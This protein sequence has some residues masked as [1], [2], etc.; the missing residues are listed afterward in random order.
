MLNNYI[1]GGQVFLHKIRMFMQ[2]FWRSITISIIIGVITGITI[3][4]PFLVKEDLSAAFSYRKAALADGFDGGINPIK[5]AIFSHPTEAITFVDAKTKKGIYG[6]NLDP[7]DVMRI[8]IFKQADKVV[9]DLLVRMMQLTIIAT[10]GSFIILFFLWWKFGKSVQSD[11]KVKGGQILTDTEVSRIL[12]GLNIASNFKIG[13]MPLVKDSETKHFL[14][15]GATGSGKTNLIDTILPQVES[16]KQ[17]AIV[18]DQT[19]E[20]ISKYYNPE[21]GDIIFNPLDSRSHVWDFWADCFSENNYNNNIN[22]RLE[23]FA[24]ILFGFNRKNGSNSDPFWENSAEVVFNS[25]AE[26]VY[27]KGDRSV[28]SLQNMLQ[29]YSLTSLEQVLSN[30]PANRYLNSANKITANS[31]LSVMTTSTRPLN[32]LRDSDKSSSESFSL[33][34][35]LQGVKNGNEA[36]LFLATK[37]SQRELT[38]PLIACL[39]ELAVSLLMENGISKDQRLWFVLDEFA[40]LGRLPAL[41]GLMSEGRKYGAC[42]LAA[43]QSLNQLY[44]NYGQYAGS[45]IFGQFGSKFF[46]RN[47][48]PQIAKMIS[49]MCGTELINKQQKNTSFGANEFRDGVSYTEQEKQKKLVEYSDIAGLEVGECYA[50]LPEPK[51]RLVKLKVPESRRQHIREEYIPYSTSEIISS[52]PTRIIEESYD[53]D[54]GL[55]ANQVIKTNANIIKE[56]E[57]R[58]GVYKDNQHINNSKKSDSDKVMDNE[59]LNMHKI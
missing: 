52:A 22:E 21:R 46:F 41:C 54:L 16:R 1:G 6:K 51:T 31:I 43:M 44:L 50:L 7:R 37:P 13:K 34:N 36:W 55:Q 35:Y 17:P 11:H 20:M 9:S 28:T 26:Y 24:K 47:D 59:E 53:T 19:G 40:A 56:I 29:N 58:E 48:E 32:Y 25:C 42:V 8:N 2:V 33:V 27:T 4:I 15:C 38:L 57:T 14:V 3:F 45:T 39:T 30:S 5:K 23:K 10:I 49:D 12:H 18:I